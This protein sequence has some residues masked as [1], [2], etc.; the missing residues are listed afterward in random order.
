LEDAETGELVELDT[1][2]PLV[3]QRFSEQAAAHTEELLGDLRREGL[4]ALRLTTNAPY[5]PAL[6]RFFRS[7]GRARA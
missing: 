2:D 4:D 5:L 1:A 6:Q 7:R 3:R